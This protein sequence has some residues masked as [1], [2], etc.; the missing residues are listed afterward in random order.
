VAGPADEG[1][2]ADRALGGFAQLAPEGTGIAH[3]RRRLVAPFAGGL[4]LRSVVRGER[5]DRVIV[6][7]EFF[8][9]VKDLADVVVAFHQLVAVLT[10]LGLARALATRGPRPFAV[11]TASMTNGIDRRE[12][13]DTEHFKALLLVNGGGAVALLAIVPSL[14]DKTGYATL[15][16][17][18]LVGVLIMMIGLVLAVIHNRYRRKCSLVYEEHG[19]KPPGGS[20]FGFQLSRPTVCAISEWCMWG[21]LAAFVVAGVS[22]ASV[23][24]CTVR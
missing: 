12:R 8:E 6:E 18:I 17:A 22:V 4:A 3:V 16:R 20:L 11:K 10:D 13:I 24:I 19:M 15:T 1:E 21:S 5:E 7:L 9:S 14:L 23:G 2:G